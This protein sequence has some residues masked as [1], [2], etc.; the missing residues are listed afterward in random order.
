MGDAHLGVAT[1]ESEG[2]LLTF[3]RAV[4][5]KA[6]TLVIMGDLFDFW[7]AW[8]HVM[9]RTGFRVL[10]A[11]ADLR[12]AGVEVLWIGGNHDCWGGETLMSA[13]GATYTLEP[14]RDHIGTWPT[15]L[16]HGDGL[17]AREDAP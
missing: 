9:P 2:A 17:R 5:A 10:A 6:R 1:P 3:L 14:W 16:V 4:P 8:R 12:D 15:L 11:I 13:T 7:F